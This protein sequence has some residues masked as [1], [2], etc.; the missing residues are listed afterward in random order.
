MHNTL[1]ILFLSSSPCT[2]GPLNFGREVRGIVEAIRKAPERD[3]LEFVTEWAVRVGDLQGALLLHE[4]QIVHFSGHGHGGQGILLED[5]W[6]EEHAVDPQAL[7]Q[8]FTILK[9]SIRVIV[10]NACESLSTVKAFQDVIDYTIG[11]AAPITDIS[12][13]CFSES[14]YGALAS[15][16]TVRE[17]FELG[18][19]RLGMDERAEAGVPRLLV[20]EG[21]DEGSLVRRRESERGRDEAMLPMHLGHNK[22]R[23]FSVFHGDG[24]IVI[25]EDRR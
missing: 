7:K 10:L 5:E 2:V 14:F 3:T 16:T 6:G 24:N 8:L 25:N 4:P 19:T 18:V 21:A 12:A 11:M 22:I 13:I 1:K 15:G 9:R 17:A 20:R 23:N